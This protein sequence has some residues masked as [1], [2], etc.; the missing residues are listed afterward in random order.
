[1]AKSK[2]GKS[3][4][5]KSSKKASRPLPQEKTIP[6]WVDDISF[7]PIVETDSGS[8]GAEDDLSLSIICWNVL[9]N[10]YC[11][12]N[13]HPGLP[14]EYQE[15]VFSKERRG[16]LIRKILCSGNPQEV[17][18]QHSASDPEEENDDA[19]T[20]SE[21][22]SVDGEQT[23]PTKT[24]LQLYPDIW[25]LQEVDMEEILTKHLKSM[26][27]DGIETP[28]IKIGAGAGGNAVSCG[29]YFRTD[30]W[31]LLDQELIRLD[32]LASLPAFTETQSNDG[33]DGAGTYT[34]GS[35]NNNLQGLQCSFLRRNVALL[36]RLQH[37][38]APEK[39][40]VVAVAH[41]FWNPLYDY[42]KLCQ[43]H[44]I[45]LRAKKFLKT[46]DEPLVVA[47]DL[48]SL[49]GS[50]VH[51]Y[52][53]RGV[54]NAKQVAPWY[55]NGSTEFDERNGDN[56][57]V[58]DSNGGKTRDPPLQSRDDK[59]QPSQPQIRYLLDF[60]LN[61]LCRW[62]R[63]VG[64]DVALE[65]DEEE[66]LR[67]RDGKMKL[68]DR[69]RE[70]NRVLVTTSSTLLSR[71]NCPSGAYLIKSKTLSSN[72][73]IVMA[74]I[75]LTHGVVLD[76]AK[77]LS[78]CVVCNGNICEVD[79]PEM[80][81]KIFDD[82]QAPSSVGRDSNLDV[83]QCDGCKQGYWW[84]DRPTSSATR[85][86]GQATRLYQMC[87]QA[88]VPVSPSEKHHMFQ[89]V[90]I[91][92]ERRKGWDW[93][94]KGS[95]LLKLKLQVTEWL[96]DDHLTCP[97]EQLHS[98]YKDDKAESGESIPFTNV[99]RDFEGLLDYIFF[100]NK[101]FAATKRLR[102]PTSHAQLNSQNLPHGHLLPSNVWPSDHIMI[103]VTLKFR[104]KTDSP[105]RGGAR[106]DS[107]QP[108]IAQE[109]SYPDAFTC[110]PT[111]TGP[112]VKSA[113]AGPPAVMQFA[114]PTN[115][116]G[117]RC[118]CGCVPNVLSLF[119]MAELRKQAKLKK[120]GIAPK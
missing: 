64:L 118:A 67:T 15:V 104:S 99:T 21:Q 111:S 87:I 24:S 5:K 73:E 101:S 97:V 114:T 59:N 47:G 82:H 20:S 76:P 14:R 65:T 29:L 116:H 53:S 103:G 19:S 81:K 12:R 6:S 49:P 86:K 42:V 119:E 110:L 23:T 9:A 48:N 3:N 71:Q 31:S 44:Y 16:S 108:P 25:A 40:V 8:D 95:E 62:M 70:E 91:E 94:I 78:R 120:E 98:A 90:D 68:F 46:E 13:S 79:D 92:E 54:V 105:L 43:M 10:G 80:K 106:D 52:L 41:L 102:I 33:D 32:D 35:I 83:Y 115:M 60:T 37:K 88:Q 100:D 85:A 69:C 84:C 30:R 2:S 74:H 107:H 51:D 112:E 7:Q 36:V 34:I 96:K 28:R 89:D 1:M 61:R 38:T 117:Q 27:Y 4:R 72:W 75:L 22:S 45:M 113:L 55:R 93:T 66:K 17:V 11:S 39:T 26:G 50:S 77:F 18:P 109:T 58:Y 57:H 63:I 56:S